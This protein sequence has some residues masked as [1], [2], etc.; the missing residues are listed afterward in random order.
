MMSC[1]MMSGRHD[2]RRLSPACRPPP[3]HGPFGSSH[4]AG[5]SPSNTRLSHH[6][7]AVLQVMDHE[8]IGKHGLRMT[9]SNQNCEAAG[10]DAG[11]RT[12]GKHGIHSPQC[13]F[14]LARGTP[15][16]SR[17]PDVLTPSGQ[18]GRIGQTSSRA[19]SSCTRTYW[20]SL[21][22]LSGGTL[23]VAQV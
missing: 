5:G 21:R 17:C 6:T 19:C 16:S 12:I 15:T 2:A 20:P 3:P 11:L 7:E 10:N 4:P 13:P 22:S 23:S 9:T 14:A 8:V 18:R 1:P